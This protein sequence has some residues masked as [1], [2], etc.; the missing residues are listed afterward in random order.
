VA[1]T[2]VKRLLYCGF[3]GLVKRWDKCINDICNKQLNTTLLV[4]IYCVVVLLHISAL[5]GHHQAFI[6]RIYHPLL[7]CI[8]I[9]IR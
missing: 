2:T 8:L 1:E 5:L 4:F 9:W 7:C 6:T 3:E